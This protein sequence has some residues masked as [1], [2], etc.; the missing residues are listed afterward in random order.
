VITETQEPWSE[1]WYYLHYS[2]TP[3]HGTPHIVRIDMKSH[4]ELDNTL[5]L[6]DI[7]NEFKASQYHPEGERTVAVIHKVEKVFLGIQGEVVDIIEMANSVDSVIIWDEQPAVLK[8]KY[9]RE[10]E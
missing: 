6:I 5:R 10:I 3:P 1:Y 2:L 9:N 8:Y 7:I 4:E